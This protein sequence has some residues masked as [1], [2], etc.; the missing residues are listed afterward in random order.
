[1][2]RYY[3]TRNIRIPLLLILRCST[4]PSNL[5]VPHVLLQTFHMYRNNTE[6]I[7]T[8]MGTRASA[9]NTPTSQSMYEYYI[10]GMIKEWYERALK[11]LFMRS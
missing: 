9:E 5:N 6:S 10:Y 7:D 1:M 4:K 3:S 2:C 8:G 11:Y